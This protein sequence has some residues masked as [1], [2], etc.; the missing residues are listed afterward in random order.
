M[1]PSVFNHGLPS[2]TAI[3]ATVEYQKLEHV[4][5]ARPE[6]L[7][8]DCEVQAGQVVRTM[9]ASRPGRVGARLCQEMGDSAPLGVDL[10]VR[11]RVCFMSDR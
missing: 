10:P 6:P 3:D 7:A 5:Q 9:R 4:L 8:A 2:M 11:D 1:L